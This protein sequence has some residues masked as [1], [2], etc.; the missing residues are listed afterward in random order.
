MVRLL[1]AA[2]MAFALPLFSLAGAAQAQQTP[3][4]KSD[5]P[6][7]S[8]T[9]VTKQKQVDMAVKGW[10][11]MRDIIGKE[12]INDASPP[13]TV[14]T[15]TD[16][17][18]EPGASVSYAIVD[19]GEFVG[20]KKKFVLIEAKHFSPPVAGKFVIPGLNKEMLAAAPQFR[21]AN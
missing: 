7:L 21:Y 19:V 12:I 13:Q 8:G 3:M 14:G 11:A 1:C 10:S 5:E 6:P 20:K 17:I 15:I 4:V 16:M 9:V 2:F 18:L